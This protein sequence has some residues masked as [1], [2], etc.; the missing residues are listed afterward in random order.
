MDWKFNLK[1]NK[2]YLERSGVIANA[3]A[4]DPLFSRFVQESAYNHFLLLWV[5][6]EFI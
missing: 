6:R 3:N 4:N 1:A 5:N 2:Q